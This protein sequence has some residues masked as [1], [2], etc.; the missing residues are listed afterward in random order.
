MTDDVR[1]V[2]RRVINEIINE[3]DLDAFDELVAADYVDHTGVPDRETYRRLVVASRQAF[4]DLH[5]AIEDEV[6]E[7]DRWVGRFRWSA[8]HRGEFMGIPPT[9]KAIDIEGIGILRIADGQLVERWNVTD[10][11]SLLQQIGAVPEEF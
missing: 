10:V 2:A 7:G 3:G 1:A 11:L 9:G 8:T 6:V 5:L 4:P